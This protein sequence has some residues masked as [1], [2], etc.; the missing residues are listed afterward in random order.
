MKNTKTNQE[1]NE[2]GYHVGIQAQ[3]TEINQRHT[4][5][6][7]NNPPAKGGEVEKLLQTNKKA[8]NS[9]N[10]TLPFTDHSLP[11]CG[12]V[13][14]TQQSTTTKP[15]GTAG[16]GDAEHPD[17]R[18]RRLSSSSQTNQARTPHHSTQTVGITRGQVRKAHDKSRQEA[19]TQK[20]AGKIK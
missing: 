8:V 17:Q 20:H 4:T 5:Q 13:S 19:R 15:A 3:N 16:I 1:Y 9:N 12:S 2:C 11:W 6:G 7:K 14:G 18:N 10:Y